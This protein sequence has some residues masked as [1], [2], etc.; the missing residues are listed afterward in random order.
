MSDFIPNKENDKKAWYGNLKTK[1]GTLGAGLGLLAG[2]ITDVQTT[3]DGMTTAIDNHAAAQTTAKTAKAAKETAVAT[4]EKKLR[5]YIRKMKTHSAYTDEKGSSL[6]IIGEDSAI[7]YST[8]KPTITAT[9]M[10]GRVRIDFAKDGLDGINIYVRLKGQATWQKLAYDSY[11]PYE[12]NRP[13]TTAGTPEHREY[14][15]I[16]VIHDEEVTLQS[17]IIEAVYGG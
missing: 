10:P 8:Y 6:Q 15:A 4:G 12:D 13:L 11:S 3:C 16:G 17:D 2:D 5:Q 7:D 1:T 14:M 9:V